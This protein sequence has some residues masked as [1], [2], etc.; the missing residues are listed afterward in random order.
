MS[1]QQKLIVDLIKEL[2]KVKEDKIDISEED[3]D[4]L[5]ASEGSV[6]EEVKEEL[7][8]DKEEKTEEK[9]EEKKD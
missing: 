4:P 9:Q 7:G 3:L 5:K 8:I 2:N 6:E 1:K